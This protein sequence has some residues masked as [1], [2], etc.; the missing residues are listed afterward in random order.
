MDEQWPMME[1]FIMEHFEH[2]TDVSSIDTEL[3]SGVVHAELI[4]RKRIALDIQSLLNAFE[5]ARVKNTTPKI[6][7]E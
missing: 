3:P 1:K 6:S 5:A 4:A 2:E 7:Y